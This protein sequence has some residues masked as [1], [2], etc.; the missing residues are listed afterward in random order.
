MM[1][2]LMGWNHRN[3][4]KILGRVIHANGEFLIAFD[5]NATEVYLSTSLEGEKP[6]NSRTPVFPEEWE[7]Q[8]GL[9]YQEHRKYL[10]I[11]V[12]DGYA[13]YSLSDKVS[14]EAHEIEVNP[15]NVTSD[16]PA[17]QGGGD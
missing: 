6:R 10:Q 13:V 7:G 9:P 12:F 16:T 14:R 8:F 15:T 2:N 4:Y 1:I 3:R 11:N 5:L 17:V